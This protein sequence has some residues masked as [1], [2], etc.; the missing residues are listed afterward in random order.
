MESVCT[1][2]SHGTGHSDHA[3]CY[4]GCLALRVTSASPRS[5][6]FAPLGFYWILTYCLI[7]VY[8]PVRAVEQFNHW[9][10]ST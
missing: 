4:P 7:S 3:V 2:S 6:R 1:A 8:R 10:N 9:L 5:R